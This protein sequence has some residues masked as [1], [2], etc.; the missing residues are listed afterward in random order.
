MRETRA[1]P[2]KRRVRITQTTASLAD[3]ALSQT[4]RRGDPDGASATPHVR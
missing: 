3:G 2:G 1:V 4:E